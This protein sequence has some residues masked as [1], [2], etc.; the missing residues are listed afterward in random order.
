[1][2]RQSFVNALLVGLVV[3]AVPSIGARPAAAAERAVTA[4]ARCQSAAS[5]AGEPTVEVTITNRSA[6]L[7]HVVYVHS[8][9]TG[10]TTEGGLQGLRL[11][12]PGEEAVVTIP[13][14][15]TQTLA[16]PWAGSRPTQGAVV[17]ALVVTSAGALTPAC[18][19]ANPQRVRYAGPAPVVA[20]EEGQE[21]ATI[22]VETIGQLESWRAYP[23][24]YALLHP[25][26]RA[27]ISFEAMACWYAAQYGPPVTKHMR[28]IYSTKVTKVR[29]VAWTWGVTGQTYP[30]TAE[31]TSQQTTGIFPH[32][33]A[34]VEAV[35]HLV[36]VDGV[37]RWFFGS[38]PAAVATLPTA[39]GLPA[40][41]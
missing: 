21:S 4:T 25:D 18:G 23:A 33:D 10:Q 39:C 13:D 34:P 22:A 7:L 12:D 26:A 38:D 40:T 29:W 8:F 28:T 35:A 6:L 1:M 24:L 2:R 31:V 17:I 14:G 16:A 30:R 27:K 20:G 5:A 32:A 9:A 11:V 37:W 36:R 3:L 41:T 19:E 15:A